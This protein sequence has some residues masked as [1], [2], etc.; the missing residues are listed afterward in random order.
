[1]DL[2][3][4]EKIINGK[5]LLIADDEKDVLDTLISLLRDC[6]IDAV[7]SFD[8]AKKLLETN[9]YDLAILD[10]MGVDGYG[11]L[12]LAVKRKIPALM[13]TAHALSRE[14]L[15]L[16]AKSGASYFV[17]KDKM[18]EIAVYVADVL[19]AKE[20][21]QSAWAKWFERLGGFFDQKFG[22]PDWRDRDKDLWERM[23]RSYS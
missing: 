1:M 23:T 2:S 17:P 12:D 8:E 13:L 16:S 21:S 7:L 18:S 9:S 3:Q 15:A 6:R 14:D 5:H 20:K 10:I 11:L 4:A 22:G 19:V